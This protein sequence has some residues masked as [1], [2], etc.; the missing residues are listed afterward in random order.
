MKVFLATCWTYRAEGLAVVGVGAILRGVSLW[1]TALAWIVAG[2]L[3]L[4][5]YVMLS[6]PR[7]P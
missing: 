4:A 2:V 3:C 6:L 7:T 1:S 5:V